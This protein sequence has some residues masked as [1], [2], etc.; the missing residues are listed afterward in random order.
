MKFKLILILLF[1]FCFSLCFSLH[2]VIAQSAIYTN[3]VYT[4]ISI[5]LKGKPTC[6]K[7]VVIYFNNLKGFSRIYKNNTKITNENLII[8]RNFR[9]CG[10]WYF[11]KEAIYTVVIKIG[12]EINTC[13]YF[14]LV[15]Q[16]IQ[17]NL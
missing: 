9:N 8:D 12:E 15:H 14:G 16:S 17:V 10:G 2:K 1:I 3:Q 7:Q 4:F 13:S 6:S 11:C 5:V